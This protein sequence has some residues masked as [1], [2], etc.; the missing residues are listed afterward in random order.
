M[1]MI[2]LAAKTASNQQLFLLI[3]YFPDNNQVLFRDALA[4]FR[5][6]DQL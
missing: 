5:V 2:H 4:L 6:K 1:S 3:P